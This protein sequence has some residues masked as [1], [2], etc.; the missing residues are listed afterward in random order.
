MPHLIRLKLLESIGK[1]DRIMVKVVGWIR[2]CLFDLLEDL[3]LL[4]V[5]LGVPCGGTATGVSSS[6]GTGVWSSSLSTNAERSEVGGST[7]KPAISSR[8]NCIKRITPPDNPSGSQYYNYKGCFSTVL[9]AV[10]NSN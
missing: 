5:L 10:L 3:I 1:V 9:M 8:K 7:S 6:G 4:R 2:Q